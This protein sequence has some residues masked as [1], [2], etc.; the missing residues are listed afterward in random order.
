[1]TIINSDIFCANTDKRFS[2]MIWRFLNNFCKKNSVKKS[3]ENV[4]QLLKSRLWRNQTVLSA[5][6]SRHF[7]V[8]ARQR[9]FVQKQQPQTW[10]PWKKCARV[11]LKK[12]LNKLFPLPYHHWFAGVQCANDI[13]Q[14]H[15]SKGA[16]RP[17]KNVPFFWLL[18]PF[19]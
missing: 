5:A 13:A 3:N 10:R 15:R 7:F 2:L 11:L 19:S 6:S 12:W 17:N 1:M 9:L 4:F 18:S 8:Q 14:S 16:R